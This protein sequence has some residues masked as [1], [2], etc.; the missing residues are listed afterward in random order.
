[1][2]HL[3]NDVQPCAGGSEAEILAY[4]A[5]CASET[6]CAMLPFGTAAPIMALVATR[7]IKAGEE[8]LISYGHS[9]WLDG[10][11][12]GGGDRAP[13]SPAVLR[14]AASMWG[15]GLEAQ[16]AAL[17]A[18]YESEVQLLEGLLAKRSGA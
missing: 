3:A 12:A 4:Y 10:S 2:A 14:A 16:V 6:N 11:S 5:A 8:L 15:G 18:A 7:D 1:M 13:P 17:S 9:Y